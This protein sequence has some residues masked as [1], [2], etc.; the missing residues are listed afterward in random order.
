MFRSLDAAAATWLKFFVPRFYVRF[1]IFFH[2]ALRK[3]SCLV[4]FLVRNPLYIKHSES[5]LSRFDSVYCSSEF[6]FDY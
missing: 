6:C 5:L 3:I 4:W 1:K 2:F